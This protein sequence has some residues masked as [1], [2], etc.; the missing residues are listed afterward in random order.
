MRP[1]P[2]LVELSLNYFGLALLF[3]A[4]MVYCLC[5]NN[6]N[7]SPMIYNHANIEVIV[8]FAYS[9]WVPGV[10]G[11]LCLLNFFV[12]FYLGNHPLA[13]DVLG[14]LVW[15]GALVSYLFAA[16]GYKKGFSGSGLWIVLPRYLVFICFLLILIIDLGLRLLRFKKSGPFAAKEAFKYSPCAAVMGALAMIGSTSFLF[17]ILDSLGDDINDPKILT[18]INLGL[19]LLFL[20]YGLYLYFKGKMSEEETMLKYLLY[21]AILMAA[22]SL[23]SFFVIL[24]WKDYE[25]LKIIVYYWGLFAFGFNSIVAIAL[26]FQYYWAHKAYVS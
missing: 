18:Y 3:L 24:A 22:L 4:S 23:V 5:L 12:E 15:A 2:H 16:E 26:A 21:A 25:N 17:A 7:Y 9:F 20:V 8:S 14:L 13:R 19:L 10:F 6:P 1:R 11:V